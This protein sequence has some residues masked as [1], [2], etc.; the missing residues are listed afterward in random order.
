[1]EV[2]GREV[3][4]CLRTS[5]L[6]INKN[7]F[8]ILG[9]AESPD[10]VAT[11]RAHGGGFVI[12]ENWTSFNIGSVKFTRGAWIVVAIFWFGSWA[13]S[14]HA[15]TP[16]LVARLQRIEDALLKIRKS[17]KELLDLASF[18]AGEVKVVV[19]QE[20]PLFGFSTLDGKDFK[21]ADFRGKYVLL[22]F[23][24]VWCQPSKEETLLLKSVQQKFAGKT[25]LVFI[26]LSLDERAETPAEFLKTAGIERV[27]GF[28][29][30]WNQDILRNGAT[31]LYGVNGIPSIWLISPD[32]KVLAKDLRGMAVEKAID[33]ALAG[34][35]T[36][37]E[38]K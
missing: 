6:K 15:E 34:S 12:A 3:E 13:V 22:D 24:S 37:S 29:G 35:V 18:R 23:W 1:M 21:L 7:G 2:G 38:A 28:L 11:R 32:G 26:G 10:D 19:G 25:N 8:S 27:E 17:Q 30:N 36:P 5:V 4:G 14:S 31:R 16:D 33:Q 9:R 20:A